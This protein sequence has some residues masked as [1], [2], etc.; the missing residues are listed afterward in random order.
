MTIT[1]AT[2][3]VDIYIASAQTQGE[4]V[5][6]A[7]VVRLRVVNAKLSADGDETEVVRMRL[8][9]ALNIDESECD[10]PP[11]LDDLLSE[12]AR[13]LDADESN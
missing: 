1:E 5:L 10:G 13:L 12:V 3:T 2:S 4:K 8:V 11:S 9:V 7:E 6:A